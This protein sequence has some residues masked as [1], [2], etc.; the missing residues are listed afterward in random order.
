MRYPTNKNNEFKIHLKELGFKSYKDVALAAGTTAPLIK[1]ILSIGPSDRF[2][3]NRAAHALATVGVD[4]SILGYESPEKLEDIDGL[5]FDA[6][7]SD[8]N[9][10][11]SIYDNERREVVLE[12]LATL[13]ERK[14][15]I[16][17]DIYFEGSTFTSIASKYGVT[18]NRIK[19]IHDRALRAMRHITRARM[20]QQVY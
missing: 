13:T 19:Q 18:K 6:P 5:M 4:I 17:Y 16:L 14:A 20:L 11:D 15:A 10:F 1:A 8:Y 12:M 7:Q 3:L 2:V 9:F